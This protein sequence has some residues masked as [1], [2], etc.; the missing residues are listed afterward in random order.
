MV[1]AARKRPFYLVL[2]LLGALALGANDACTGWATVALYREPIDPSLAGEGIPDEGDRVALVARFE[3]YLRAL[4]AARP[5]G[6]PLGIATLLLGSAVLV[7][8][9]RAL[10]GSGRA[11]AAL[12]QLVVAQAGTYAAAYWLLPG[13]LEAELHVHEAKQAAETHEHVPERARAD[14]ITR[15]TTGMLRAMNP[16][17]LALRTLGSALVVIA[18]TRRRSREFFDETAKAVE[19]Q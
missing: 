7:F 4:D 19:E 1:T 16:L 13:V 9:T 12:V 14:E 15:A 2:A 3:A 5:R 17:G 8:A 6:W 18:L 10:G 11:R